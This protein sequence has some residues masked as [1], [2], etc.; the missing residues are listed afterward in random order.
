MVYFILRFKGY[1]KY[2]EALQINLKYYD[3]LLFWLLIKVYSTKI[4]LNIIELPSTG[5]KRRTS[6]DVTSHIINILFSKQWLYHKSRCYQ[7]HRH[8]HTYTYTQTFS[9]YIRNQ[10]YVHKFICLVKLT[11]SNIFCPLSISLCDDEMKDQKC[12]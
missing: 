6:N 7:S 12:C 9:P 1:S 5:G 2:F 4:S 3:W 8:K 11:L 10:P